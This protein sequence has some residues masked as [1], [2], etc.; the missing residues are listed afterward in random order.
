AFYGARTPAGRLEVLEPLLRTLGSDTRTIDVSQPL[1]LERAAYSVLEGLPLRRELVTRTQVEAF[2]IGDLA[3]Q[4]FPEASDDTERVR[5]TGVLVALCAFAR[6]RE[7]GA[8]L[9][10]SRIHSF[11]RGLP[12]LWICLNPN[13]NGLREGERGGTAGVLYPQPRDACGHCGARV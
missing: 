7:G 4:L 13:C 5:A 3:T 12:G 11:H 1:A 6:T 2:K 9:L 10:P 8:N